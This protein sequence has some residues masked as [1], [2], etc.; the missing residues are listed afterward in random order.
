MI[1]KRALKKIMSMGIQR[2]EAQEM[3]LIEHNKGLTNKDALM[4]I[5]IVIMR[6]RIERYIQR[7]KE[8]EC[9]FKDCTVTIKEV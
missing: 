7:V 3:L 9:A 4:E 1:K 6:T 5:L 2:N 8:E